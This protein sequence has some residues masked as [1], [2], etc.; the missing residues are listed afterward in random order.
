M[1]KL[2]IFALA[3]LGWFSTANAGPIQGVNFGV[4][5]QAGVF[6]LDGAS[7]KFSGTHSSGANPGEV[8]KNASAEG[9]NAEGLFAI[10][11]VFLELRLTDNV[12]LGVDYV[13]SALE[14]ETTENR[15]N[16]GGQAEFL[17][18]DVTNTVQVDFE[19]LTTYYVMI[20]PQGT[21]P[22]VKAGLMTVDV[23]TN[24]NLASGG[25]YGNTSL[26]GTL[27]GLGYDMTRDNGVFLRAEANWMDFDGA[28]LTNSNDTNKSVTADGISGYGAKVSIGRSF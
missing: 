7:E 12:A 19:D 4:S 2:T 13:P 11:S 20:S 16:Q 21:G 3:L 9:E 10:G 23:L 18:G 22:Y 27:L 28:T 6:E 1:K 14:S 26:D 8:I 24:E 25:A 15:Q 17:S 5:L